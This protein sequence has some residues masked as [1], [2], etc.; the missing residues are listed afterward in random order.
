[1]KQTWSSN[2]RHIRCSGG[3]TPDL[4]QFVWQIAA[5]TG[6]QLKS[7]LR[8]IS[9]M[10]ETAAPRNTVAA[11]PPGRRGASASDLQP[12][13]AGRVFASGIADVKLK[14]GFW[15]NC[16]WRCPRCPGLWPQRSLS[17]DGLRCWTRQKPSRA[18]AA[19]RRIDFIMCLLYSGSYLS[20]RRLI[21]P[22]DLCFEREA[23]TWTRSTR[24]HYEC[25]HHMAAFS[26]YNALSLI[27]HIV[28]F[29]KWRV[30]LFKC[31][32]WM[33]KRALPVRGLRLFLQLMHFSFL[34]VQ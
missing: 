28:I 20:T 12:R 24:I 8:N 10:Q 11:K 3:R 34:H 14:T 32:L 33:D 2:E 4:F 17:N 29:A 5:R 26:F 25:L 16:T 21:G 22:L 18:A 30:L 1:M 7:R 23:V 31:S 13:L 27:F 19:H 6:P 9:R 15:C